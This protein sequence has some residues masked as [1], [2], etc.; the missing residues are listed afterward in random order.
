MDVIIRGLNPGDD[1]VMSVQPEDTFGDCKQKICDKRGYDYEDV[2]LMFVGKQP[3]DNLTL[4]DLNV[5]NLNT[6]H[7]LARLLGD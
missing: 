2:R 5:K 1:F 7:V 6:I 3:N 4:K